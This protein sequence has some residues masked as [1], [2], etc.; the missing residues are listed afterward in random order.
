LFLALLAAVGLL[1]AGC[2]RVPQPGGA[3]G[4]RPE[5]ARKQ[6]ESFALIAVK[7]AAAKA[8]L[9]VRAHPGGRGKIDKGIAATATGAGGVGVSNVGTEAAA[10]PQPV[11]PAA[12]PASASPTA[13]TVN[14]K[15]LPPGANPRPGSPPVIKEHV[16]SSPCASEAEADEDAVA[17]CQE[18][19]ERR[20]LEL[21]PP[22]RYR[23]TKNEVRHEFTRADTRANR[24]FVPNPSDRELYEKVV[25][26]NLVLVEYDVEV[27]AAQVRELRTRD[28]L[29]LTL[30]V[31]GGL[32]VAA[33][34]GFLFLR[35]DEWTKGYLTRWLAF[36]A[37]LLAGGTAAALYFV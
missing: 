13:P 18:L 11:A 2:K 32:T 8:D 21:D 14:V 15:R 25:G 22:I 28:R 19:I 7:G 37:V 27:T 9:L 33:L 5:Q 23:P 6:A 1:G 10:E 3:Q 30:R 4:S 34:A 26:K 17:S 31:L 35:A 36:A 24:P 16:V 12:P 20:L 29:S